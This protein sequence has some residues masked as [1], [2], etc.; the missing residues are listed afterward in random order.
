MI[1]ERSFEFSLLI[2][3][4]VKNLKE[5]NEYIF[6]NQLLRSATSIGANV[7]EASAGQSKIDFTSKIAIASKEARETC[8]WLRLIKEGSITD[9]ELNTYLDEIEQI[10][11]ILTKIVKTSQESI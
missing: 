5:N 3:K 10:I 6:A 9:L 2:I 1:E 7:A 11:K 8:Y 4:L